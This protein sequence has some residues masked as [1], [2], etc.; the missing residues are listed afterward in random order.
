MN[1]DVFNEATELHNK[2]KLCEELLGYLSNETFVKGQKYKELLAKFADLFKGEFMMFVHERMTAC[3]EAFEECGKCTCE[4][5]PSEE[6]PTPPEEEKEPIFEIGSM[7]KIASGEYK[8]HIGVV[9][10]YAPINSNYYVTSDSFSMWFAERDLEA[11]TDGAE[12]PENP[13]IEI[14]LLPEDAK[15]QFG[16]RVVANGS[17]GTIIGYDFSEHKYGVLLDA[18][19]EEPL[20][21]AESE[22]EKYEENGGAVTPDE[23]E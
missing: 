11:Y 5:C 10:D 6:E 8:G 23:G 16:D 3:G 9:K 18:D 21:Y 12:E 17:V 15:F 1:I 22:L 19:D 4:N 2:Y 7:V 20:W 14:P 13:P